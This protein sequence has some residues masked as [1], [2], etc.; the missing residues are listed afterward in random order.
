MTEKSERLPT[1]VFTVWNNHS[2]ECGTPPETDASV[3]G[4]YCGYF[5]NEHKEQ[6]IFV[7]DHATKQGILW[8]GDN[9]WERPIEVTDPQQPPANLSKAEW[10]WLQS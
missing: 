6:F 2:A 3:R 1:T 4:K 9:G 8:V 5:E 10:L 7:Y